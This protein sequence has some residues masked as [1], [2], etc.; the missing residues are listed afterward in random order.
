MACMGCI[1]NRIRA[2]GKAVRKSEFVSLF[3]DPIHFR[4]NLFKTVVPQR[5]V[6]VNMVEVYNRII[7]YCTYIIADK[8]PIDIRPFGINP[9]I[10]VINKGIPVHRELLSVIH[11]R[12]KAS[13]WDLPM[14][15]YIL[16]VTGIFG[17]LVLARG[18]H[19]AGGDG[20]YNNSEAFHR[21]I[22]LRGLGRKDT[23]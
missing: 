2:M 19:Y 14:E 23:K 17:R 9:R 3:V 13:L 4:L 6:G 1:H 10:R 11:G 20:G 21:A 18:K 5:M 22:G 12:V 15:G 16:G 7:Y 8:G